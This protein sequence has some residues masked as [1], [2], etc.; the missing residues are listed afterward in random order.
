MVPMK[1]EKN[2]G[3]RKVSHSPERYAD[4]GRSGDHRGQARSEQVG[5]ESV[6]LQT[7]SGARRR[8]RESLSRQSVCRPNRGFHGDHASAAHGSGQAGEAEAVRLDA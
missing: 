1:P 6:L 5:R 4:G 7:G 2:H 8:D 3:Q